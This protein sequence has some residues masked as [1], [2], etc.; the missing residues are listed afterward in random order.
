MTLSMIALYLILI[1]LVQLTFGAVFKERGLMWTTLVGLV[2]VLA[3]A[4]W[5]VIPNPVGDNPELV[6]GNYA[7][8]I[9]G[10]LL[11][12]VLVSGALVN[13][14]QSIWT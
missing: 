14:R 4:F 8:L 9:A 11:V 1:G 2:G 5:D 7:L 6:Y 13:H 10:V 12:H 3:R